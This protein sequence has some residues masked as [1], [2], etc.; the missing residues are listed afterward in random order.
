MAVLIRRA[1]SSSGTDTD[2]LAKI[3]KIPI[4]EN[5]AYRDWVIKCLLSVIAPKTLLHL[6]PKPE[7][8]P[9][10]EHKGIYK[11]A[12]EDKRIKGSGFNSN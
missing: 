12:S 6:Y 8:R 5:Y 11:T 4:E 9:D 1:F 2:I 7:Y 10:F 3:T